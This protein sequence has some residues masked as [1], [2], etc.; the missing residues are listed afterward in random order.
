[1]RFDGRLAGLI[2]V[3]VAAFAIAAPAAAQTASPRAAAQTAP[4]PARPD[5]TYH[6]RADRLSGSANS[7]DDV[8]TAIHVTVEHGSTTVTGDSAHVYRQREQVEVMGNVKIVDGKTRMWGD[9]ATYDRKTRLAILRGNVRI[10]E[11]TARIT[12][13]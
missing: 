7:N 9:E 1:M 12:G 4:P 3:F 2:C 6:L 13:N 11:G 10:E 5:D 8:Y